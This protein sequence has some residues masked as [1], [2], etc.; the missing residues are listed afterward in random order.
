[1]NAT[2]WFVHPSSIVDD[3]ARI[4]AGTKIWHFCHISGGARIGEGCV[5]GQGCYVAKTAVIG[6]RVK[7]QNG[8]SI[9]DGVIIEDEVFCGPHMIFTNVHNPRAFI[10]R[11]DEYR[12]TRVER[13]A[14]IGAG[15][16]VVCGNT[17]GSYAFI[18]A[19]AVVTRDVRPFALVYGNPA[20]QHGWVDRCG[21]KLV[22]DDAGLATGEDGARYRLTEDGVLP[23]DQ[24]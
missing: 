6:D 5:F 2:D 15:A 1:M 13:G 3:G 24:A 14:S 22:F 12:P 19:G 20:K 4:G 21:T 17:V 11:K 23:E 16:I 9:Y 8:V 7:V 18:G 10:E